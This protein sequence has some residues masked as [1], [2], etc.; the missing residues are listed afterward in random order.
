ME[1]VG[2]QEEFK[3]SLDCPVDVI[4]LPL[5]RPDKIK[6]EKVVPVYE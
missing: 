6:I 3:N 5:V 2:F 1:V 4:T